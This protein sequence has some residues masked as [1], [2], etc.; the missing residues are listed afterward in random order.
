M[1]YWF[2][3][4]IHTFSRR[5]YIWS[6]KNNSYYVAEAYPQIAGIIADY[7]TVYKDKRWSNFYIEGKS[8][9]APLSDDRWDDE[10]ATANWGEEV[11]KLLDNIITTFRRL[12]NGEDYPEVSAAL[13]RWVDLRDAAHESSF[14]PS[15]EHEGYHRF[16]GNDEYPPE[17]EE[18][19]QE[20]MRLEALQEEDTQA[21]LRDFAKYFQHLWS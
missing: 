16:R 17:V 2:I 15:D 5:A 12:E 9:D 4:L 13:T 11:D 3:N 14:V 7:L 20:L 21:A 18:A 8:N 1:R 6:V 10:D 19:W